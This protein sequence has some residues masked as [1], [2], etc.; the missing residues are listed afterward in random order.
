MDD[1]VD[2]RRGDVGRERECESIDDG[3]LIGLNVLP[4]L[5]FTPFFSTPSQFSV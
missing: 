4:F 1:G 2:Q 3:D 5:L